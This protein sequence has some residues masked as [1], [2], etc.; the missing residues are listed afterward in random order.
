MISLRLAVPA[1]LAAAAV[2]GWFTYVVSPPSAQIE[3]DQRLPPT[4]RMSRGPDA[5]A[6]TRIN[7][8]PTA[9]EQAAAAYW[10]AAKAILRRAPY[11]QAFRRRRATHRK[12]CPVAQKAPH[13]AP[14]A[15]GKLL[16]RWAG[17]TSL[18]QP[19][20]TA[21]TRSAP[22]PAVFYRAADRLTN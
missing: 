15:L 20:R 9:D 8:H 16:V 17:W 7:L 13:H 2:A 1:I 22:L 10:E 4:V 18:G 6:S 21:R 11:A 3:A 12:T 19:H 14:L 5:A